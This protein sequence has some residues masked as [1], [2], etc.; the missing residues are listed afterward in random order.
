MLPISPLDNL[1]STA[2]RGT[3][4]ERLRLASYALWTTGALALAASLLA[5]AASRGEASHQATCQGADRTCE[6][7]ESAQ[8]HHDKALA[9][10]RTGNVLLGTGALL[11]LTGAGVFTFDFVRSGGAR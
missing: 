8:A 11:S 3:S 7:Y 1:E 9:Y 6:T 4:N 10:A 5:G 2:P